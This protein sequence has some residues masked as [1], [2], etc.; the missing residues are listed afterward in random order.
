MTSLI[1]VEGVPDV[2]DVQLVNQM[3]YQKDP[4]FRFFYKKIAPVEQF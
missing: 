4:Y 1:M 2:D 3:L